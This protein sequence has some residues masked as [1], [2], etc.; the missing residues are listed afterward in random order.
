MAV[1]R[2]K[3]GLRE[4]YMKVGKVVQIRGQPFIQLSDADYQGIRKE[5]SPVKRLVSQAPAPPAPR[6]RAPSSQKP[7]QKLPGLL[8]AA[9]NAAGAVARV[10]TAAAAGQPVQVAEAEFQRRMSL[11]T[12]CENFIKE[13]QRC[14]KCA[15]YLTS[16]VIGKARMATES[17]PIGKWRPPAVPAT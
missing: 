17:C 6:T 12:A 15:C 13:S 1:P 16:Q 7:G 3:P 9:K 5:F 14:A 4:A 11:C 8:I 2:R 10:I